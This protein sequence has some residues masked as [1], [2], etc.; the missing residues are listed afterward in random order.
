MKTRVAVLIPNW[1]GEEFIAQCLRSLEQQTL[2]PHIVVVDNGSTDGSVTIIEKQF[3]KVELLKFDDNAGFAGGVNRGLK[4][5]IKEGYNYIALF[6]ND[7][8]AD[9]NWLEELVGAAE[10]NKK[11]GIITGKFLRKDGEHLDSTGDFMTTRGMPYPR[12]RNQKDEGQFDTPE[13]IFSAS[14]GASIYNC[15]MLH[16]IGLFDEDFFAYFEDVDISFRAQ[17]AGWKVWYQPTALAYHH[18]GGTSQKLGNFARYHSIKNFILLYNKNMPGW[19]FW[20]YK[21]LFLYQLIRLKLGSLRDKDFGVFVSAFFK[22]VR[23]CPSTLK[24]RRKIQTQ[25]KVSTKYIEDILKKSKPPK[26]PTI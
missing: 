17:L 8:E 6:N 18:V 26:I 10:K 12:G 2:K 24:K 25:R 21:P 1:N 11:L 19:L 9:K 13:Y 3:P 5:L 14:G 22:A 4:P 7:A 20:K 16:Q 23:L 15:K